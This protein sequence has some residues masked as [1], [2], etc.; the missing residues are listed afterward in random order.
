MPRDSLAKI[1][2]IALRIALIAM[3]KVKVCFAR[4]TRETMICRE[5]FNSPLDLENL[6]YCILN[7]R[8]LSPLH[9]KIKSCHNEDTIY[10]FI[11]AQLFGFSGNNK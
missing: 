1:A 7:E 9:R 10:R 2:A 11:K 5:V 8:F 6:K 4:Q 3:P